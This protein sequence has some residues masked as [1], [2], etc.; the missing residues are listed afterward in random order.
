MV[1]VLD[2]ILQFLRRD[3]NRDK[4]APV[5]LCCANKFPFIEPC[6][7]KISEDSETDWKDRYRRC[8]EEAEPDGAAERSTVG[9]RTRMGET[10]SRY[11]FKVNF[12]SD[13]V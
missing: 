4:A 1:E 6:S 2:I 11:A 13:F 10:A 8:A 12:I 9:G 5:S 7:E 3:S